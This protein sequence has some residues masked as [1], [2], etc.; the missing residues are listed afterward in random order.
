MPWGKSGILRM[1]VK[2]ISPIYRLRKHTSIKNVLIIDHDIW[3]S[4]VFV[5][6]LLYSHMITSLLLLFSYSTCVWLS[7]LL[8]VRRDEFLIVTDVGFGPSFEC[9]MLMCKSTANSPALIGQSF[10][11]RGKQQCYVASCDC[12]CHCSCQ[13]SP[14][15]IDN[16][17]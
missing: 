5:P 17:V 13:I 12:N 1:C 9:P 14:L 10:S 7:W 6:A 2:S 8:R 11:E 16:T 15:C 4:D 3:F